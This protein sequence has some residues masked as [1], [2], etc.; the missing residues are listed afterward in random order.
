MSIICLSPC[1]PRPRAHQ[2]QRHRRQ[3]APLLRRP[4]RRHRP[5]PSPTPTLR[6]NAPP[7]RPRHPPLAPPPHRTTSPKTPP[8]TIPTPQ[9]PTPRNAP[10][11]PQKPLHRL[12]AGR[13]YLSAIPVCPLALTP[14]PRLFIIG[15]LHLDDLVWLFSMKS[16]FRRETVIFAH[17]K[18]C[19]SFHYFVYI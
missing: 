19:K 11:P 16:K 1:A 9:P 10:H 4:P 17:S 8:Q 6:P 7:H 3:R 18:A 5:T 13:A 14:P 12:H 15:A 2:L